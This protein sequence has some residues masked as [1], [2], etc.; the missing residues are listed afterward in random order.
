MINLVRHLQVISSRTDTIKFVADHTTVS[1][2][3]HIKSVW[4][5][6][7][8]PE[9]INDMLTAWAAAAHVSPTRIPGYWI[10]KR[11]T[12]TPNGA[13]PQPGEKIVLHLHGGA[14][15]RL[16]ASPDDL[17]AAIGRGLLKHCAPVRRVFALEYR[18]SKAA[19]DPPANAFPAA[20]L[21]ALA[22][23]AYL[24]RT[25]GF[26]P[27]DIIVAGDSAGGNLAHALVR[28]LVEH[29]ELGLPA[30][31]F[32]LLLSPWMDL[33]NSHHDPP[34]VALDYLA[35]RAGCTLA[36]ARGAFFGS[37]GEDIQFSRYLSPGSVDPRAEAASFVGWPKTM[38]VG[39]DAEVLIESIRLVVARMKK[40]M[41]ER[42]T[43]Y[44]AVD[45]VHDYLVLDF[46]EPEKTDT[47]KAIAEW[48]GK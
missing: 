11:G 21:D 36:Y 24:V 5:P 20:L 48:V 38:V 22:G 27:K 46:A 30:P 42:V 15:I 9:L 12:S 41:G 34:N 26:A 33:S 7:A 10:D 2:G 32:V 40:D 17:V 44:E 35:G 14:Y 6:P 47:L 37:G 23:Y 8:S 25:V 13:A 16:S 31:G 43:Y 19:P 1:T 39:G 3:P 45:A 4:V 18:L 28:Y 29:P